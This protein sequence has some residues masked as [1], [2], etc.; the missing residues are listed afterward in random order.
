MAMYTCTPS[1]EQNPKQGPE[2]TYTEIYAPVVVVEPTSSNEADITK[3][4]GEDN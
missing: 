1:D 3:N 2:E 4:D